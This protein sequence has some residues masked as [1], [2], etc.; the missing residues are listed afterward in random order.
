MD[1]IACALIGKGKLF[2]FPAVFVH[3]TLHDQGIQSHKDTPWSSSQSASAAV[4]S[5]VVISA[6]ENR[7]FFNSH[8]DAISWAPEATAIKAAR[9][10]RNQNHKQPRCVKPKHGACPPNRQYMPEV[11]LV[12]GGS[13]EHIPDI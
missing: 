11:L 6:R 2:V 10:A 5:C 3:V 12:V 9:N 8:C 4:A 7:H 1:R 13:R